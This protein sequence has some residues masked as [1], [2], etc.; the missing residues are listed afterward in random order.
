MFSTTRYT[1]FFSTHSFYEGV[2]I[3]IGIMV[4]VLVAARYDEIG[5]GLAMA[6]GALCVSL[7]DN[8][9]P[10]HHRINGMGAAI[11]FILVT[12]LIT[13]FA[14][15]FTWLL[16]FLLGVFAFLFSV[17]GVFGNRAASIGT[18]VLVGITLQL[19][20][21]PLGVWDN[22]L[23]TA[24]GGVWYFLLSMALYRIRPYKLAQQVLG[25]CITAT[26]DFLELKA[27]FYLPGADNGRLYDELLKV[28]AEVHNKQELA[29]EV[30]FKTRSI[31]KEST[32]TGRVLVMAF[33]DTVDLFETILTSEQDHQKLQEHLSHTGILPH[34]GNL[35]QALAGYLKETGVAIQEGKIMV[36]REDLRLWLA[37]LEDTYAASRHE[38]MNAE[39]AG[40]YTSL[41]QILDGIAEL[42]TK[43]ERLTVYTSYDRKLKNT[44]KVE[45]ERFVVPS[46]INGRLLL[47]NL[48]F[49]SNIFRYSLRMAVA[50]MAGYAL[51]LYLPVGHSYWILLTIVVILKPAYA[52][53]RQR[54]NERLLGTLAGGIA[55]VGVLITT[56]NT[57]LLLTILIVCMTGA[58]SLMRT[59]YWLSVALLTMY[60][61]V[62]LYLLKP[63]DYTPIFTDRLL[64]T[65]I[66]S[67]IAISFTRIIPPIWERDQL[68]PLLIKAIETNRDYFGYIA[69]SFW[70]KSISISQYKWYR[71][72]TYVAL[73]NLSE[74]FQ[75]MLNEPKSRQQPGEFL[76]PM[77]VSCHVLA[78]RIATLSGYS[79]R[80]Q[81]L[82]EKDLL[83]QVIQNGIY[84]LETAI[85]RIL[86]SETEGEN[87]GKPEDTG[88]AKWKPKG[89]LSAKLVPVNR[90]AD[91]A[92]NVETKAIAE[93]MDAILSI[94]SEI[95][96]LAGKLAFNTD[97]P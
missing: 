29:R 10:L 92:T 53:T 19:T 64:D 49:Q 12:S 44:R 81:I 35:L 50:I 51:S 86:H 36:Q 71:K 45:Y 66:G 79:R 8:A 87:R 30:L 83:C 70:G 16:M 69:E 6:L 58:F 41:R 76:H 13:G 15:P 23:F 67:L 75:R 2:R 24:A 56:Q 89:T 78:S 14:L 18:S 17:I 68:K 4:P 27:G 94:A 93:Q 95:S 28:Q 43:I 5:W 91:G 82:F 34:F 73:A 96:N 1:S 42:L 84:L 54:N 40:Y 80:S 37:G 25:D 31:V 39:N 9:G 57:L 55:G 62:A 26:A 3:T 97:K 11:G 90:N 52:L 46:Y 32:H 33:L 63:G 77:V 72:E 47:D 59:R 38:Y 60:V 7:T 22:A 74:A 85:G 61:L 65:F 48:G 20:E 88:G 21:S